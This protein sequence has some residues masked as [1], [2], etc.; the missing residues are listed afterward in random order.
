MS[1][2]FWLFGA[3]VFGGGVFGLLHRFSLKSDFFPEHLETK[4][5]Q[6]SLSSF[7]LPI[8]FEQDKHNNGVE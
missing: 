6:E 3:A 4:A 5:F 7:E 1:E 2:L 8:I